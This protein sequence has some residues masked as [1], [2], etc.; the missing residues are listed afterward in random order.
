MEIHN[1]NQ[2]FSLDLSLKVTV[3]SI[4]NY[5]SL[6]EEEIQKVIAKMRETL[7]RDIF[8]VIDNSDDISYQEVD[9][10]KVGLSTVTLHVN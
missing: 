3:E 6:T 1:V 7:L 9:V 8:H 5:N 4:S 10:D 2:S